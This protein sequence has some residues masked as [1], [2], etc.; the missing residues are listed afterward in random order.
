MA[1]YLVTGGA[2]FIGSN[3]VDKLIE[4]G[5]EVAVIDN[6]STGKKEN[7]NSSAKFYQFDICDSGELYKYFE[8]VDFVFHLAAIPSVPI[9]IKEPV[10]TSKINILGTINVLKA[11]SDAKVK[12][13][14]FAS[15]SAVYGEQKDFPIKES[16]TL[17]FKSPYALHK[18]VGEQYA[19]LFTD[20]YKLPVICLRY[21]NVY[22]PRIDVDSDYSLVLGK[23]LKLHAQNMPLTVFGD[24][25]QTRSFCY[26]DD[27]VEANIKASESDKLVGGEI[28]NIGH[29]K[30]F[31]INGL[32]ELIGGK[33]Q[34]LPE[35]LG[36]ILHTQADISLA[37]ELLGW[38]PK[39]N[40]KDGVE[41]TKQWFLKNAR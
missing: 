22:G 14:I 38:E 40:L 19:R 36:D 2:G 8:G 32:A 13:V 6:L 1:K 33:I 26:I 41:K 5:H 25:N 35:R 34:Y 3:L 31:S 29:E 9:S 21:F 10:S 11:A 23:F 7:I 28:I 27:V 4:K 30:S 39:F 15:S 16:A 37:K 20:I 24:G 18:L 12:R 17:N